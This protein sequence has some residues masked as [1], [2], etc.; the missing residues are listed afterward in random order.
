[1]AKADRL[2]AWMNL[3]S[4]TTSSFIQKSLCE[5]IEER[6]PVLLVKAKPG[7]SIGS[8]NKQNIEILLNYIKILEE[9]E[10]V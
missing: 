4:E 2:L 3:I 8:I 10:K 1:M 7:D 5:A 6:Y 9:E